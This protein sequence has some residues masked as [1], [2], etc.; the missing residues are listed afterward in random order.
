MAT[1]RKN[2]YAAFNFLV[3]INGED[4]A[5]FMEVSG[6]DAG[7]AVI[8]Y[9]EGRDQVGFD[10]AFLRKQPGIE[11][12]PN[13]TMRRGMTGGTALWDLRRAIRD[14]KDGPTVNPNAF[15]VWTIILQDEAHQPV[16]TWV[17]ENAWISRLGGPSLNAKANEIAIESIEV[18]C[19]R[20]T[21]Q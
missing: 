13:V 14:G 15:P 20:I 6:L 17:L 10:G 21:I 11:T 8:E 18:V 12:Y 1:E 19:E 7:N 9:R 5:G 2:P 3:N 16:I 4:I